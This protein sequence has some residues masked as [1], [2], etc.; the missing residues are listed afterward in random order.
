MGTIAAIEAG[1]A[2]P[3][4]SSLR[5]FRRVPVNRGLLKRA[6]LP[7]ASGPVAAWRSR[8][9]DLARARIQTGHPDRFTASM[10]LVDE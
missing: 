3:A 2:W 8:R 4:R 5:P 7:P 1:I 9:R 10:I 6:G